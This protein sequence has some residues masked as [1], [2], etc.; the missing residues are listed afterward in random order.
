MRIDLEDVSRRASAGDVTSLRVPDAGS[1]T[2]S[3]QWVLVD[4]PVCR[5]VTDPPL[6]KV[7]PADYLANSDQYAVVRTVRIRVPSSAIRAVASVGEA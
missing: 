4:L 6:E 2:Y 7:P 1:I 3:G 5:V